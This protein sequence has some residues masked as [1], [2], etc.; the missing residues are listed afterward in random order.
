[1]KILSERKLQEIRDCEYERGQNNAKVV[2]RWN[3][4]TRNNILRIV[5][6][7]ILIGVIATK[8]YYEREG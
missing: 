1:M 2:A 7:S 3:L 5:A 8:A 6:A 4:E